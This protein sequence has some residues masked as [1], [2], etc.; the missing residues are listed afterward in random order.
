M[1]EAFDAYH[2]WLGISPKDQ[3]P[4][5]YRLLGI[6][7]FEPDSD[8]IANAA[9]KQMAHIRSFQAGEH[10]GLSQRIL[11]E[12]AAARVCLLNPNKKAAY[13]ERLRGQIAVTA[14]EPE[15]GG[16][17]DRSQIGLAPAALQLPPVAKE[18]RQSSGTR[19]R[20]RHLG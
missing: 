8:V 19:L 7:V 10:S 3:P 11:N 2:R 4:N 20:F 18:P 15:Q 5:H 6:D 17:P 14:S 1:P 16:V 13:D 9:D 12:I